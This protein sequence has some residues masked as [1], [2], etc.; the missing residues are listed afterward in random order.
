MALLALFSIG[1]LPFILVVVLFFCSLLFFLFYLHI[2]NKHRNLLSRF[3][4][5]LKYGSLFKV[6]K[7]SN[8]NEHVIMVVN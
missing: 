5:F 3:F 6:R 4:F 7:W 8:Q 2:S 1:Q